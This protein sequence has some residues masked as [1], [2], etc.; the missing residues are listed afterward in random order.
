MGGRVAC[1]PVP[2]AS[3][4]NPNPPML[5][6]IESHPQLGQGGGDSPRKGQAL[7]QVE[8]FDQAL[9]VPVGQLLD[10]RVLLPAGPVDQPG[11][12]APQLRRQCPGGVGV[13]RML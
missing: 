3:S 11:P 2:G 6:V 12:S 4:P 5:Q 13:G 1:K 8:Q 9:P 10:Q 7:G